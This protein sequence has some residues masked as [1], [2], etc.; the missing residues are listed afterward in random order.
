MRTTHDEHDDILA[1]YL[2]DK[3]IVEIVVLEA[4]K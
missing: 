4:S 1:L 2:A 3:S